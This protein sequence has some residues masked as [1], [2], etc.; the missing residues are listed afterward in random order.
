MSC[1]HCK[2]KDTRTLPQNNA[3]HLY[4]KLL[5]EALNESG[6]DMRAVI[7]QDIDIPWTPETIKEYL[8]RPVQ[9]K[10]LRKQSTASLKKNEIDKVF[11]IV[12]K[13]VGERTGVYVAFPNIEGLMEL[14]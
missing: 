12:N 14:K 4:F 8:W 6:Q 13:A 11:D 10:Y 3:L 5:A 1:E 2:L 9:K 7:R